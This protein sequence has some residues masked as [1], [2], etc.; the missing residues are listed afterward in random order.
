MFSRATQPHFEDHGGQR[1]P[2]WWEGVI[3]SGVLWGKK[4]LRIDRQRFW[5][6]RWTEHMEPKGDLI[7]ACPLL[8]AAGLSFGPPG[9]VCQN[10]T[11]LLRCVGWCRLVGRGHCRATRQVCEIQ[12][13]VRRW[14]VS[15]LVGN[16]EKW[17][18][19]LF[20]GPHGQCSTSFGIVHLPATHTSSVEIY[21]MV[22]IIMGMERALTFIKCLGCV[23]YFT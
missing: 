9:P 21:S 12:S 23:K 5:E 17:K 11:E 22:I 20:N 8:C 15:M 16:R 4:R 1:A 7:S 3:L 10:L 6:L 19:N 18:E 13:M 14:N 2:Y